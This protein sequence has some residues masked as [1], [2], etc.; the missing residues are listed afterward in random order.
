[1]TDWADIFFQIENVSGELSSQPLSLQLQ[2]QPLC[3][4][5]KTTKQVYHR[6]REQALLDQHMNL[7]NHFINYTKI[8][9]S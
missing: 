1:M 6:T 5:S 2:L 9:V 8:M 7:N 3:F 4:S